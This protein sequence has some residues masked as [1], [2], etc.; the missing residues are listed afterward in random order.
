M[1]GPRRHSGSP[2]G[3]YPDPRLASTSSPELRPQ[4]G[5]IHRH[6]RQ[7][8]RGGL[9]AQRRRRQHAQ[10]APRAGVSAAA[11]GP[12]RR[13][14]AGQGTGAGAPDL[15]PH[16]G[17]FGRS[18]CL[19]VGPSHQFPPWCSGSGL[20]DPA[21]SALPATQRAV[22][23]DRLQ[24]RGGPHWFLPAKLRCA[25]NSDRPR[26]ANRTLAAPSF[27]S[28]VRRRNLATNSK[29]DAN[30]VKKSQKGWPH[31]WRHTS[32]PLTLANLN[33]VLTFFAVDSKH[34]ISGDEGGGL[35]IDFAKAIETA[36]LGASLAR[37]W[38]GARDCIERQF[39]CD[40]AVT[41]RRIT[42]G[43]CEQ[44][45]LVMNF[46]EIDSYKSLLGIILAGGDGRDC[47]PSRE[48]SPA[49]VGPSSL[50]RGG[51]ETLLRQTR[52]RVSQLVYPNVGGTAYSIVLI[53]GKCWS[54]AC[55]RKFCAAR[56]L[57]NRNGTQTSKSSSTFRGRTAKAISRSHR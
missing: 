36:E 30:C 29:Y 17:P 27:P 33:G 48:E 46:I 1:L 9:V 28:A 45:G 20:I 10:T 5:G 55:S 34:D 52:H 50:R 32:K 11:R 31:V 18:V 21:C 13:G 6:A 47:S 15:R 44:E 56:G 38:L 7:R 16:S 49:T 12:Y 3:R 14:R 57:R 54:C 35:P 22:R 19:Q 2:F 23:A 26:A 24:R 42:S 25:T 8:H 4:S 53:T 43:E 37:C 40:S 39:C 51:N 41:N